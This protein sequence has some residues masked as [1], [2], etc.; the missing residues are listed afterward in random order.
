MREREREDSVVKDLKGIVSGKVENVGSF[1][2][3]E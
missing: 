1:F 3:M 2:P